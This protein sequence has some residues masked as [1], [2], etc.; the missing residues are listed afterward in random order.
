MPYVHT[1]IKCCSITPNDSHEIQDIK[2][3]TKNYLLDKFEITMEHKIA[4]FLSP[5][6]RKLRKLFVREKKFMKK[7]VVS[8][9]AYQ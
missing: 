9:I 7:F 1:L 8:L 2:Y 4:T 3:R 5:A 6:H